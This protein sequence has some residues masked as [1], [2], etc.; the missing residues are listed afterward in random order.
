MNKETENTSAA[1]RAAL[2]AAVVALQGKATSVS[3]TAK[4]HNYQYETLDSVIEHNREALHSCGL[5]LMVT[6]AELIEREG[7]SDKYRVTVLIVHRSGGEL[8]IRV[9]LEAGRGAYGPQ[10]V[11]GVRSYLRRYV[12]KDL[13]NIVGFTDDD[14]RQVERAQARLEEE[15]KRDVRAES[16]IDG[17]SRF[18]NRWMSQL[19]LLNDEDRE[20]ALAQI[21]QW[22]QTTQNGRTN[23]QWARTVLKRLHGNDMIGDQDVAQ[24]YPLALDVRRMVLTESNLK[25]AAAWAELLNAAAARVAS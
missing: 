17:A 18:F 10:V 2:W 22:S 21:A 20:G 7:R 24:A 14:A 25:G 19:E 9:E 11:G 3:K 4:G 15:V 6:D 16:K 12:L 5:G 13:L 23:D 8:P 1:P